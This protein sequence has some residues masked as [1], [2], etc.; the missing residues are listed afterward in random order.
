MGEEGLI[1]LF[2]LDAGECDRKKCTALKLARFGKAILVKRG[3]RLPPGILSLDPFSRRLLSPAD[4]PVARA[5]GIFGLDCSWD[6]ISGDAFHGFTCGRR[7]EPRS[8]PYLLAANPVKFGQPFRLSTVEALAA[9]LY[10]LGWRRQS[11]DVLG[12]YTWGPRFFEV[13][14]EPLE[15]YANAA[16]EPGV[17]RAQSAY[18]DP[19]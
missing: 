9:A 14:R 3:G 1:R 2:V 4:A 19:E 8:L 13:N 18:C 12:I 7:V 6:R 5:K 10:I 17:R 15:D 16:D 11:V